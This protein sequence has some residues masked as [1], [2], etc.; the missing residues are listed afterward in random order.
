MLTNQSIHW[1]CMLNTY[2]QQIAPHIC[3]VLSQKPKQNVKD[4]STYM[5]CNTNSQFRKSVLAFRHGTYNHFLS[6]ERPMNGVLVEPL[7]ALAAGPG[8]HTIYQ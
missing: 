3:T 6:G 2:E 5:I 7:F 4:V 1:D 8:L